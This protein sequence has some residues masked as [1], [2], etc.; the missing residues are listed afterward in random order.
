MKSGKYFTPDPISR[1]AKSFQC[2]TC[3]AFCMRGLDHDR[4]AGIA[5]VDA[6]PLNA[7]GE[8]V[9]LL[10][11]RATYNLAW[12]G[13]CY[14]IDFRELESIKASPPGRRA[15]VDVVCAHMCGRPIV[16]ITPLRRGGP[17][18]WQATREEVE[19]PF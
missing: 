2:P 14:E 12:R 7:Q 17:R 8:L 6:R 1:S 9:A 19:C 11:G 18:A 16:C 4:V 13:G 5:I 15:D 10:E 3:H